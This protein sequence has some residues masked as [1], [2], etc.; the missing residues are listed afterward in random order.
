MRK[1]LKRLFSGLI[2]TALMM[3]AL[4]VMAF[5]SETD[6]TGTTDTVVPA[7]SQTFDSAPT[8]LDYNPDHWSVANGKFSVNFKTSDA[9]NTSV[10]Y[11]AEAAQSWSNYSVSADVTVYKNE[12]TTSNKAYPFSVLRAY[13][14]GTTTAAQN[15]NCYELRVKAISSGYNLQVYKISTDAAGKR[16]ATKISS[17]SFSAT[18]GYGAD[19]VSYTVKMEV[20]NGYLKGYVN[21]VLY[22]TYNFG[23]ESGAFT[24]G[25]FGIMFMRNDANDG[26]V[27]AD[28][29]N[30]TV[31]AV[32]A[33]TEEDSDS[34]TFDVDLTDS[35]LWAF[36]AAKVETDPD[37]WTMEEDGTLVLKMNGV[38]QANTTARYKLADADEWTNYRVG[39]KVTLS[40]SGVG[41][42][43]GIAT[44]ILRGS[45]GSC[46]EMRAEMTSSGYELTLYKRAANNYEVTTKTV[47]M[48]NTYGQDAATFHYEVEYADGM[49]YAYI[50]GQRVFDYDTSADAG[51]GYGE[52]LTKG[53]FG[54]FVMRTQKTAY[55]VLFS[56]LAVK[57][58][59]T[60]STRPA[61]YEEV[62][63]EVTG[64]NS[65]LGP[66]ESGDGF[67][68]VYLDTFD[69]LSSGWEWKGLDYNDGLWAVADGAFVQYGD[70]AKDSTIAISDTKTYAFGAVSVDVNLTTQNLGNVYAGPVAAFSNNQF[71][72]LRLADMKDGTNRLQLY[73]K[74][75]GSAVF[76]T[77]AYLDFEIQ[78]NTWYRVEITLEDGN[79]CG[80]VDGKLYLTHTPED[81]EALTIGSAGVR[82][83]QGTA[84]FDNFAIKIPVEDAVYED[85]CDTLSGS[86]E[87]VT[88]TGTWS[89]SDGAFH[90]TNESTTGTT[91]LVYDNGEAVSLGGVSMDVL[92]NDASSDKDLYAGPVA[93][94]NGDQ[95]YYHLCLGDMADGSSQLLLY[96]IAGG[97]PQLLTSVTLPFDIQRNTWYNVDLY[98]YNGRL[99][100]SVDGVLYL[101]CTPSEGIVFTEGLGGI[102][103]SQ[104]TCLID[105][106][107][108]YGASEVFE[109]NLTN[110]TVVEN[111]D[112][113]T[114]DFSGETAGTSPDYWLEESTTD[115][116]SVIDQN[117][118]PVYGKTAADPAFTWLHVFETN[119]D[120]AAKIMI[121]EDA[122]ANAKAGLIV[123]MS[124]EEAWVIVGYDFEQSKWYIRD[125][126]GL[127][128]EEKLTYAAN[129]SVLNKGQW[130]TVRVEA[131]GKLVNVYC[132]NTLVLTVTVDQVTTG[133]VGFFSENCGMY[134]DDITLKLL[135]GQGRVEKAVVSNFFTPYGGG[136]SVFKLTDDIY[137]MNNETTLYI[138]EDQGHSFRL[139]TAEE[140]EKY[141]FF[142]QTKTQYIRLKS[143]NILKIDNAGGGNA[144]LS[145]DNGATFTKVGTLLREQPYSG[146][147]GGM[148]DMLTEVTLA[149][150][151]TR[152]FYCADC[153]GYNNPQ[154]TGSIL[155]HW[156]E[157]YYTDDEGYTWHRSEFDTR[158]F[159]ALNH[160]CESRIISCSDGTLRMYCTW[161]ESSSLRYFESVDGGKTWGNEQA[162]PEISCPRSSLCVREDPSNPGTWYMVFVYTDPADWGV[163]FPRTRLAL[164]RT[165]D[166]KNWEYMM[167]CWRWEDVLDDRLININQVVNPGISVTEDYIF[168]SSGW[169]QCTGDAYGVHNELENQVLKINKADLV[170]YESFPEGYAEAKDIL[171]ITATAPDK[172]VYQTGE[173]LDLTGGSL[174]V[175]YYDGTTEVIP[176]TDSRV[177]VVEPL[178]DEL[179]YT[180]DFNA[181]DMSVAGTK[182]LRVDFENFADNITIVVLDEGQSLPTGDLALEFDNASVKNGAVI[183][184]GSDTDAFRF[185]FTLHSLCGSAELTVGDQAVLTAEDNGQGT[186]TGQVYAKEVSVPLSTG[187][188]TVTVFATD[189]S[190]DEI[191]LTFTVRRAAAQ[192]DEDDSVTPP[193]GDDDT[194]TPPAGDD[195]TTTPPAGDDDTTT[196]PAGDDD[197]TT[198]PA[199]D[200]DTT[201][202]AEDNDPTTSPAEDSD[203]TTPPA[204]GNT[205]TPS[206]GDGFSLMLS[207]LPLLVS[208]AA[209]ALL[210]SRRKYAA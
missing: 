29:D 129:T 156:E 162:I 131:I 102:R 23:A 20:A 74:I 107:K 67:R 105:N 14:D 80:Y 127:D 9:N 70:G 135:S 169:S 191:R 40:I 195:D 196:P 208:A 76:V 17:E 123:R 114:D 88:S 126:K 64:E 43:A 39:T 98:Q 113:F 193:A 134:T 204:E 52:P 138:S 68:T 51:S 87:E 140:Y 84:L 116:W 106:F 47:T 139:A 133:R 56:D 72:V 161:N 16:T 65:T 179:F 41:D 1:S 46:Y 62:E 146:F 186:I 8:D 150:G 32:K 66:V 21:D 163:I 154:G 96:K 86:W 175:S 73:R 93:A 144:Y 6:G 5:T 143:G 117:G 31:A 168:V 188:N 103:V 91:V 58:C 95:N 121:P 24:S 112:V 153:R 36:A 2:A 172:T 3:S 85:S 165:T 206:T 174:L 115:L 201:P 15:S 128:F 166:G 205:N 124:G 194:T 132:D 185:G 54:F 57:D 101:V 79:V 209:I 26:F 141:S 152:V 53:S 189:P 4:P 44:R 187:D 69:S 42:Y 200:D 12:N 50:D 92:F 170:P 25:S 203:P 202:P 38:N 48:P 78:R 45:D 184:V 119:V 71:Y 34:D 11:T 89:A 27:K 160:I 136:T 63:I 118:N 10:A 182:I 99:L 190:G 199:G 125:R 192:T 159:S 108:I 147:Y 7:Y 176:M 173:A 90:Q 37:P 97:S 130:Y 61:E 149:D 49:L 148:N 75:S 28:V 35:S 83:S 210:I 145:T 122:A 177:S 110:E 82:S 158:L 167:D 181:P 30:L 13:A 22:V 157:I 137:L 198:P 77:E 164:L 18:S 155:Y 207:I 180:A 19:S 183:E 109:E 60:D 178:L 197:T 59:Y 151:S 55:E 171:S 104:G 111:P 120:Y 81:G 142:Q 94:Y 33:D 100:G